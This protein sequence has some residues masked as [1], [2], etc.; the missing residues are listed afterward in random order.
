VE[1]IIGTIWPGTNH[2]VISIPDPR[3]GESLVLITEHGAAE[4]DILPDHFRRVGLTEL[5]IPRRVIN[6]EKLPLLG[7]GKTDYVRAR[8]L[9]MEKLEAQG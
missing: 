7:T 2:A 4:L 9:V 1:T 5:S 6:M 8:R 3:K